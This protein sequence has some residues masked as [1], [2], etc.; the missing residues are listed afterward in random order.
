MKDFL[1]KHKIEILLSIAL[2]V[3]GVF[4]YRSCTETRQLKK[5]QTANIIALTDTIKV[6]KGKHG[7]AVHKKNILQGDLNTLKLAN[8]ELYDK[9]KSMK[10]KKV[11]EVV[12]VK[13][14][15]ENEVHDTLW[16]VQRDTVYNTITKYFAFNNKYRILEGNVAVSDTTIGVAITSDKVYVDYTM[17]ISQGKVHL[18]SDNP[19]VKFNEIKGIS[20]PKPKT[21]RW[22]IGPTVGYGFDI[23]KKSFSP[24]IGISLNYSIIN[25]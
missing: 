13:S 23:S 7:E 18:T 14:I 15:I 19:Y 9:V 11:T 4:L 3:C 6:Y 22:G 24:F 1:N 16:R 8:R 10:V 5:Q 2:L 25:W 20:L 12:E 17:A 21:K